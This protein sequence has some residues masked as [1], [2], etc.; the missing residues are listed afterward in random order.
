MPLIC[1]THRGHRITKAVEQQRQD[2][3]DVP[4]EPEEVQ[5]RQVR[6]CR[7]VMVRKL[8]VNDSRS[9]MIKRQILLT[10]Q[11]VHVHARGGNAQPH[12]YS[13]GSII[14]LAQKLLPI[15]SSHHH[16]YKHT[17]YGSNSFPSFWERHSKAIKAPCMHNNGQFQM[18]MI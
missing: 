1:G 8:R 6:Q 14:C 13:T 12:M 5:V 11:L 10:A 16:C 4:A 17:T 18:D 15:T 3:D 9:Q 7:L 2:V